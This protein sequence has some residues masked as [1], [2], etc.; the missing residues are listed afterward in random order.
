MATPL[1]ELIETKLGCPLDKWVAQRR[2]PAKT[3]REL[4]AEIKAET[5]ADVSFE[6]LRSWFTEDTAASA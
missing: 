5:G 6:T 3:W 4:A 1:Y 2:V